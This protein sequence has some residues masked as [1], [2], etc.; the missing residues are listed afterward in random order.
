MDFFVCI[1]NQNGLILIKLEIKFF[2]A[3]KTENKIK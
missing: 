3:V 2:I 1:I